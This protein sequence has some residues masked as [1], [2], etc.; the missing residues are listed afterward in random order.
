VT[1]YRNKYRV[2]T[3]RLPAW[4]YSSHGYYFVT[5]CTKG[6]QYFFGDVLDATMVLSDLGRTACDCWAAIPEHF[7]LVTVDEFV[8]MPNHVHGIIIIRPD[9]RL[10]QSGAFGPQSRNL[11]SIVRG[12][13]IGV[14]KYATEHGLSFDWQPR[15]YEHVIRDE[16]S[17]GKI[18]NYIVTNPVR[19]E[20]DEYNIARRA[21]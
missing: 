5:I 10:P 14:K 8:V 4:D 2:E 21:L 1:L 19:W 7:P 13:K 9:D 6:K 16:E 18:R 17:L 15:F 3:A 11:G 20:F 12:Y